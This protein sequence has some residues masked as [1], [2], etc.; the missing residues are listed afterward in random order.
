MASG[1]VSKASPHEVEG[2]RE[3]RRWLPVLWGEKEVSPRLLTLSRTRYRSGWVISRE[4]PGEEE[5]VKG[6]AWVKKR[7]EERPRDRRRRG[8]TISQG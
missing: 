8:S 3:M 6:W 4:A 2:G 7:E 5:G 1:R